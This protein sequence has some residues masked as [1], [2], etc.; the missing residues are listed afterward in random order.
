MTG[1]KMLWVTVLLLVQRKY[2]YFILGLGDSGGPLVSKQ[3]NQWILIG[4]VSFS[5]GCAEPNFP[6]V[7]ARVS[8]YNDWINSHITDNQPGFVLFTSVGIDSDFSV[9][10]DGLSPAPTAAREWLFV[11]IPAQ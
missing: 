4:V 10:C 5:V 7:Y 9:T 6:T 11:L 1:L 3:G 2:F 8:L